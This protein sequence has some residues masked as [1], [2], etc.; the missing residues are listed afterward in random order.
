MATYHLDS[1]LVALV[2]AWLEIAEYVPAV[3]VLTIQLTFFSFFNV[4]ERSRHLT[5]AKVSAS[6]DAASTKLEREFLENSR[7]LIFY[8]DLNKIFLVPQQN[9]MCLL[10]CCRSS[11]LVRVKHI[12][13]SFV[14]KIH[15][16]HVS[17][18]VPVLATFRFLLRTRF[19]MAPRPWS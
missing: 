1:W 4:V 10:P 13:L 8:I 18:I 12:R 16:T 15:W 3:P 9:V 17:E 7:C 5:K 2:A 6:I 11:R 14:R 19:C